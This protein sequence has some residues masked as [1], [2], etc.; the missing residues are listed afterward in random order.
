[1]GR[2]RMSETELTELAGKVRKQKQN[3]E[4]VTSSGARA[5]GQA[6]EATEVSFPELLGRLA[7]AVLQVADQP[8]DGALGPGL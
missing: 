5:V 2:I 6:D 3:I 1:M 8:R 7:V 4:S